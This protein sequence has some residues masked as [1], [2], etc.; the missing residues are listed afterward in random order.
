MKL[1]ISVLTVCYNSANTISDCI[2]SVNNQNYGNVEH[3][4][5]DGMSSDDT[6]DMIMRLSSRQ[7]IL[8]SEADN[9]IYDALNKGMLKCSGDYAV[10]LHSDDKFHSTQVISNVV[11]FIKNNDAPDIVSGSVLHVKH[12][13]DIDNVYMYSSRRFKKRNLKFGFIPAHNGTF[14]KQNVYSNYL[15]DP[16]FKS[17][18]D[19][20]WFLRVFSNDGIVFKPAPIIISQQKIGGISTMG[21]ESYARS[22]REMVRAVQMNNAGSNLL[23]LLLRLPIKYIKRKHKWRGQSW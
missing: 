19:Y 21:V 10:I 13:D 4:F 12:L 20:E 14:F 5:I 16:N 22:T 17:A 15:Y 1:K 3:V 9:G 2:I 23:M 6:V 8:S 7:K 18:G 11:S